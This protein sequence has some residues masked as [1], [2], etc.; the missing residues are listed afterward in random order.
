VGP[1]SGGVQVVAVTERLL[2]VVD[3]LG[4]GGQ[5]L[6]AP[7]WWLDANL[8]FLKRHAPGVSNT[9]GGA[10][11]V[12]RLLLP[13]VVGTLGVDVNESFLG[14]HT[15][16]TVTIGVTLGRWSRPQDYSNPLNPLGAL[17]PTLHYEVFERVR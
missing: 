5:G 4:V 1:P 9:A 15:V 17:V 11:R 7:G 12:S 10:V 2:H 16:G 13:G 3:Q 14:A 6:L 8:V